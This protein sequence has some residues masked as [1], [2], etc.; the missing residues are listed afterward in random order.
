MPIYTSEV[1]KHK[2]QLKAI[3]DAGGFNTDAFTELD[4]DNWIS[5]A[6][7]GE[8]T[9][10]GTATNPFRFLKINSHYAEDGGSCYAA[11]LFNR[12]LRPGE[13]VTISGYF[14]HGYDPDGDADAEIGSPIVIVYETDTSNIDDFKTTPSSGQ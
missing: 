7:H 2:T 4:A 13:E 12:A 1:N 9:V 8:I 6:A 10:D 5:V 14:F 3:T 11:L